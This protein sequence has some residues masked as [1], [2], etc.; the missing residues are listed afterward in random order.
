MFSTSLRKFGPFHHRKC[1]FIS[2][3]VYQWVIKSVGLLSVEQRPHFLARCPFLFHNLILSECLEFSFRCFHPSWG[4]FRITLQKILWNINFH[5]IS[6]ESITAISNFD[7]MKSLN[8]TIPSIVNVC[9]LGA[10]LGFETTNAVKTK[11]LFVFQRS[12]NKVTLCNT[13]KVDAAAVSFNLSIEKFLNFITINKIFDIHIVKIKPVDIFFKFFTKW[14]IK[15]HFSF[16]FK[17][18]SSSQSMLGK[19]ICWNNSFSFMTV[20]CMNLSGS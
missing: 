7:K 4:N 18:I 5:F 8:S 6:K 3:Y 1:F 2:I 11:L 15:P 12:R 9:W 16:T 17:E 20:G 13:L 19:E 14:S 10:T